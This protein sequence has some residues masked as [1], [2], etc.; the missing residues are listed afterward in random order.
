MLFS[1]VVIRKWWSFI[2]MNIVYPQAEKEAGI[3][4]TCYVSFVVDKDGSVRD[5]KVLR[6]VPNGPGIDK[7]AV[8]VVMS[9]PKWNPGN[10]MG[11][12]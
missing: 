7:E 3:G 2:Q 5:V 4:G 11:K 12:K 10:K 6:G 1:L 9:M 8:R